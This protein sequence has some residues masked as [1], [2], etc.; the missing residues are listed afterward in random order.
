MKKTGLG[1][2]M[3]VIITGF[4]CKDATGRN[5]RFNKHNLS[6]S[7]PGPI[8]SASEDRIC[9]FCHT[10][11]R[12]KMRFRFLWNRKSTTVH[13]TPYKSS[14]L[15]ARVGQPTGASRVCLSCH[16]GTIALGA[17]VSEQKEIPFKGGLRFM[18]PG[19]TRLGTDLSDDHPIS[20]V[21]DSRLSAAKRELK[22]P[23]MLPAETQLDKTGQMQ[24]TACHDPHDDTFGKFLVLSNQYSGLCTACHEKE[25]WEACAHSVSNAQFKGQGADPWPNADYQSVAE[26]GCENC[27]RPHSAPSHERLLKHTFEEDNCLVCH[28]GNVASANIELELIKPYG[29]AVQDYVGVHDAAEVFTSGNVP[30]HVECG[31]CHNP[32]QANNEPSPGAPAVSGANKGVRGINAGG[33]ELTDVKNLYEICFKCHA[34]NNVLSRL[35]IT[36]QIDQLNTRLE[37]DPANPS[38]HPI[39][40]IGT[41]IDVP[42]LLSPYTTDS[43]IT[44]TNCHNSDNPSGP[45]GPHGS[46]YKYMLAR[47]YITDDLTSESSQNYALC[48]QCHSR[49]SLLNDESFSRHKKHIVDQKTPCSVCHDPHGISKTQGNSANNSHLIN[50]DITVVRPNSSGSLYFQDLGRF[51]GQCFLKCHNKT[52]VAE[53]Y[54]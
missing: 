43:I 20:F 30:K 5:I 15:H 19:P 36:R 13:Y 27:H 11:G 3:F 46:S 40:T 16:D 21:Y 9:I 38:L 4:C 18:P 12:S 37:F 34:D 28:N 54:P 44:C 48:Y 31:D 22:D 35:L 14:T 45:K 53:T 2:L 42:S 26:N 39:E 32:H 51:T 41:N 29:H 1:V 49:S 10:I 24:C 52:H 7:G 23:S 8:K 50:F 6:V 33:Q 47:N 17:L 25:G